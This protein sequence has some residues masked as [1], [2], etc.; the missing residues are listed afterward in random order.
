MYEATKM[1]FQ[2]WHFTDHLPDVIRDVGDV[3][4]LHCGLHEAAYVGFKNSTRKYL[5][6]VK[7]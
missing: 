4:F 5:Y 3:R 6:A 1:S 7:V 2:K